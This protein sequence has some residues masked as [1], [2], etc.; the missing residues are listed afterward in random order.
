MR[1]GRAAGAEGGNNE[2]GHRL[3]TGPRAASNA[4]IERGTIEQIN[5]RGRVTVRLPDRIVVA[6]LHSGS[7]GCI[8]DL[9]EGEMHPGLR[10]W[11]NVGNSILSVVQVVA[12]QAEAS[13]SQPL[14]P[15]HPADA[16][17]ASVTDPVDSDL[18]KSSRRFS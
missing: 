15:G 13:Q 3:F 17:R 8:G 7:G 5:G 1:Q 18:Q 10:S 4:M 12:V 2:Y 6:D 11:R 16:R 14:S 9:V